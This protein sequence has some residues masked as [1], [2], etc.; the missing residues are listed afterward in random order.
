MST[1]SHQELDVRGL[2]C[3]YPEMLTLERLE[4]LKN[5]ETLLVRTDNPPSVESIPHK[6]QSRGHRVE[7]VREIGKGL[8]EIVIRKGG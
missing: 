7:S 5:G 1:N 6:V 8:W 4:K 2:V 3:P